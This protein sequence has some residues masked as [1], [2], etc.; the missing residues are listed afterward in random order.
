M[1][2][3]QF[4]PT[5]FPDVILITPKVFADERGCFTETYHQSRFFEA[6]IRDIFV[7]DN[8]SFSQQGTLRGLHFQR[9]P[10]A[11]AKLVRV[12]EGEIFDVAVDIRPDSPT[13][14]KWVGMLL[15]AE[16]KQMLYIP[17]GFA[18]GFYVTSP[19]AKVTYKCSEVYAPEAEW[20]LAWNDP[21]LNI[22]WPLVQN[23]ALEL[24][25]KDNGWIYL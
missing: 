13:Y 4:T 20:G 8:E 22:V 17:K 16:N 19:T 12:S 21:T 23:R 5:Q 7:Q 9:D 14:L 24:S 15:S 25:E 11:Q 3:M 18:H 1:F 2:N 6:G 10:K